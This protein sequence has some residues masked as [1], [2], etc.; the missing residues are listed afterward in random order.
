MGIFDEGHKKS[1]QIKIFSRMGGVSPHIRL[2]D[3]LKL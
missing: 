3:Y 2:S 1:P